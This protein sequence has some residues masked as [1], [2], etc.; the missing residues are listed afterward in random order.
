LGTV[1]GASGADIFTPSECFAD[2]QEAHTF[3]DLANFIQYQETRERLEIKPGERFERFLG[4][5]APPPWGQSLFFG[6][7]FHF[8]G[9]E[10]YF[11]ARRFRAFIIPLQYH[12]HVPVLQPNVVAT[13]TYSN[14]TDAAA[15]EQFTDSKSTTASGS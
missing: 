12:V 13:S 10:P 7:Y 6:K 5:N 1:I 3:F 15:S 8:K 9:A 11:A 14:N 4:Y 2:D